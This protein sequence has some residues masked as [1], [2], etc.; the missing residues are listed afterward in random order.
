[1]VSGR[2]RRTIYLVQGRRAHKH[3]VFFVNLQ[4]KSCKT[5]SA[6]QK[7]GNHIYEGGA[8]AQ[9]L[10]MDIGRIKRKRPQVS[11]HLCQCSKKVLKDLIDQTKDGKYHTHEGGAGA[12]GFSVDLGRTRTT[13]PQVSQRLCYSP[14]ACL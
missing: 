11:R 3:R 14:R 13:S 1:M 7:M 2:I 9:D 12:L 4:E 6:I 10:C 8:G 5:C